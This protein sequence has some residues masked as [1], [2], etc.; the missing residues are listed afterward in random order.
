[1]KEIAKQD[2]EALTKAGVIPAN[3]PSEQVYIFSNICRELQLS[4]FTKE[5]Y[6]LMIGGKYCPIVSIGGLRKMA[7]RSGTHAGTDDVKFDVQADGSYKTAAALM[8]EGKMPNTATC[9]I[10]R[11][12]AGIRV[13]YTAT[14]I[15]GEFNK[16]AGNWATMPWQMLGK[17]A[18]A[19]ALRKGFSDYGLSGV[20]VEE[21]EHAIEI[22]EKGKTDFLE[23]ARTD[24]LY[25]LDNAEMTDRQIAAARAAISAA[26]TPSEISVIKDRVKKYIPDSNDPAVQFK[27]RANL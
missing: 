11:I 4:P 3:T 8:A 10:Y 12:V 15:F 27:Q 5:V 13:P 25:L 26:T 24:A 22:T 9:T 23:K 19:F 21:E 17:V 16:K 18:E 20:F 2:F 1:M 7:A 14:V 6:L